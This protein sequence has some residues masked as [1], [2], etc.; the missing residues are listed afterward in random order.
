MGN[1]NN[2]ASICTLAADHSVLQRNKNLHTF[3]RSIFIPEEYT[4][5]CIEDAVVYLYCRTSCR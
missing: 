1:M 2:N 4:R 5:N 3:F